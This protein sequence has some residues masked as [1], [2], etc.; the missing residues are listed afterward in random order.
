MNFIFYEEK[1]EKKGWLKK[2]AGPLAEASGD[3][4]QQRRPRKL[5]EGES[6]RHKQG[7]ISHGLSQRR[8]A[9]D[10]RLVRTG[11]CRKAGITNK[12]WDVFPERDPT[13]GHID[14][15]VTGHLRRADGC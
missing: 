12:D 8:K 7:A 11:R 13:Q 3:N 6:Q 4:A 2:S 15:S 1:D 5:L 9:K 14:K 10:A